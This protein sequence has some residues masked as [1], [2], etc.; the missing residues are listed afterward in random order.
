MRS[1]RLLT[2]LVCIILLIV[3]VFFYASCTQEAPAPAST[4]TIT[5]T[6]TATVSAP[7]QTVTATAPAPTQRQPVTALI[8][9]APFGTGGYITGFAIQDIAAKYHP[10]FRPVTA[11]SPGPIYQLEYLEVY[12][13]KPEAKSYVATAGWHNIK[14]ARAGQLIE[15][16]QI[17]EHIRGLATYSFTVNLWMSANPGVVT[18]NDLI[19][20]TIAMGTP[21]QTT[22]AR[23]PVLFL[24][25]GPEI[26]D[27]VKIEYTGI[28]QGVRAWVDGL[29]EVALTGADTGIKGG[30]TF[31]VTARANHKELVASGKNAYYVDLTKELI[32]KAVQDAGLVI[33]P[34]TV[35]ANTLEQQPK[36][37]TTLGFPSGFAV[38]VDFDEEIAYELV[39]LLLD[40]HEKFV[41]YH[42]GGKT[43]TPETMVY[44]W[45]AED[46]HPGAIRA[47]KEYAQTH[48]E[49]RETFRAAG[50]YP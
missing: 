11:E 1:K 12:H 21:T 47:Y 17:S 40:H 19:G 8:E 27:D 7:A 4:T 14:A 10:W 6:S 24:E 26:L 49:V 42:A 28:N 30:K 36:E 48:P 16:K 25:Y 3:S 39:K 32:D 50:V 37:F 35:A 45:Q 41:E 18:V 43:L 23:M 15:G 5:A 22:W 46:L 20:K 9:T 38:D 13:G 31:G 2:S 33:I 34:I 29:V 44:G